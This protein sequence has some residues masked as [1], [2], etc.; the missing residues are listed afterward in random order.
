MHTTQHAFCL[1]RGQTLI[2]ADARQV[3]RLFQDL[4]KALGNLGPLAVRPVHIAGH[5]H[6]DTVYLTG[7]DDLLQRSHINP[8]VSTFQR[9]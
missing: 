1:A 7:G 5:A 8:P 9:G 6:D 3:A 4:D 2:P